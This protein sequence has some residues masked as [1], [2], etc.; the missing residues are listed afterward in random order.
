MLVAMV[1]APLRPAWATIIASFSCNLAFKTEC[2]MPFLIAETT[3][4]VRKVEN[5]RSRNSSSL[6]S[7][8][9][10]FFTTSSNFSASICPGRSN[11]LLKAAVLSPS[12]PRLFMISSRR[13]TFQSRN[14]FIGPGLESISSISSDLSI[15]TVPTSTGRPD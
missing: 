9:S 15:E 13:L 12:K 5:K 7:S 8:P 14:S 4:A 3:L 10:S 11:I 2:G 1:T 6:E